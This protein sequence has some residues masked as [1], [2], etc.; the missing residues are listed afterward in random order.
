MKKFNIPY[1]FD[2]NLLSGLNILNIEEESIYCI[3]M[4][5][6][7]S[8]Y[9][10]IQK[11]D[12]LPYGTEYL[13]HINIINSQFPNKI[14][15]LLQQPNKLISKKKLEKYINLNI[16]KFCVGSIEQAKI[17]KEILPKA[18]ITGS[19][20]MHITKEKLEQDKEDY[21]KYFNNFV[22]DFSYNRD[23][24]K[25]Y[26]LPKDFN[27]TLII[28]S[29]C[30]SKCQGDFHWFYNGSENFECPYKDKISWS[31]T[32]II[33]PSDLPLF[34]PYINN[35]EIEGRG[36]PTFSILANLLLYGNNNFKGYFPEL[37]M[38]ESIYK[39]SQN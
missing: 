16:S 26:N 23:I 21:L 11:N 27:Y 4:P 31:E 37:I 17:I 3:Y 36:F 19:I 9:K 20:V 39:K 13:E 33:K 6:E 25:I 38:D 12:V 2:F 15:L 29:C 34:D 28:N 35:Y 8:D 5:P 1:N 7:E 30:N 22:L 32:S 24:D 14:Q 10:T 18:D